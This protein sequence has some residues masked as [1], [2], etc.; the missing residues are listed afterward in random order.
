MT[1]TNSPLTEAEFG[2]YAEP[3]RWPL[4]VGTISIL[5]SVLGLVWLL[6]GLAGIFLGPWLQSTMMGIDPVAVPTALVI[7]QTVII[8]ICLVLG[9]M[10]LVGGILTCKRRRRGP[11][12]ISIWAVGRL[13]M[14]LLGIGFSFLTLDLNVQY[15]LHLGEGVKEFMEDRGMTTEQIQNAVPTEEVLRSRIL[16]WPLVFFAMTAVCPIAL[17]LVL[18]GRGIRA[19]Y[20]SW[21]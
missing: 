16:V 15:Q 11:R 3:S 1:K 7:G 17:G 20:Q 10:L 13:V 19:D 18:S 5:Y 4:V 8:L 9:V 14:I 12:L 6:I 21:E 2:A